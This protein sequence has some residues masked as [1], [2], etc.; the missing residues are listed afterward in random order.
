LL[1]EHLAATWSSGMAAIS[2][3][4]RRRRA[5]QPPGA[6][7]VRSTCGRPH[8]R[9]Q[10]F[11]QTQALLRKGHLANRRRPLVNHWIPHRPLSPAECATQ[12]KPPIIVQPD[13]RKPNE[14]H[15]IGTHHWVTSVSRYEP[16]SFAKF[17]QDHS[18]D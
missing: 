6:G 5:R 3:T 13:R 12:F 1:K 10:R 18:F 2:P 14:N 7:A 15:H 11:R 4:G 16:L 17:V 8:W 9:R